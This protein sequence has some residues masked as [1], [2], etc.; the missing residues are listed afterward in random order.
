MYSNKRI[1]ALCDITSVVNKE[2]GDRIRKVTNADLIVGNKDLVGIMTQQLAQA[3][4]MIFNYTIEIDRMFY[5]NQKYLYVDNEVCEIKNIAKGSK[6][7]LCKLSVTI[8]NDKDI[9]KAIEE[10]FNDLQQKAN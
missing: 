1:I 2:T 8:N 7:N 5:K 9:K 10:W 4:K 3:Q 6:P